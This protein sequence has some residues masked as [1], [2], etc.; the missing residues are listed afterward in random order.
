M[1]EKLAYYDGQE[2]GQWIISLIFTYWMTNCLVNETQL[3]VEF[4]KGQ[5][6]APPSSIFIVYLI[7]L[8]A[9][10]V[11]IDTNIGLL[12]RFVEETLNRVSVWFSANHLDLNETRKRFCSFIKQKGKHLFS[13]IKTQRR[14]WKCPSWT[15]TCFIID[16]CSYESF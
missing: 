10:V 12:L 2:C 13:S 9:S 16:I 6:W 1:L 15:T 4:L 3:G 7:H 11:N 8:S 14:G 5:S